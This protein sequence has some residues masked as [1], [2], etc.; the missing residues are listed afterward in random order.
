[1]KQLLRKIFSEKLGVGKVIFSGLGFVLGLTLVLSA[2][3]AYLAVNDYLL[4]KQEHPD[5]IILNKKVGIGNT[6]FGSKVA[7]TP[8]EVEDL[9][10]QPFVEGLAAFVPNQ[11][12]VRAHAGGSMGLLTD[13]FFESLPRQFIDDV[14]A[15][16]RWKNESDMVPIIVSREFLNLYNFG[17]AVGKNKPQISESTI[18][19]LPV[20]VEIY[21]AGGKM[22]FK[23]KVV[24][25]SDR[26]PSFLVPEEFMNWANTTIAGTSSEIKPSR[27]IVKVRPEHAG[28]MEKYLAERDL[29]LN[30]D[31]IKYSKVLSVLNLAMTIVI[32][33]GAAFMAFALLIVIMNFTLL[34]TETKQEISLLIQLGYKR[35]QI[36]N[37][38]FTYFLIFLFIVTG[39]SI[40]LFMV[41]NYF[42][43]QALIVHKVDLMIAP[44][45]AVAVVLIAVVTG[46]AL[47]SYYSLDRVIKKTY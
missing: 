28:M 37:H 8:E 31:R 17:F 10:K 19:M 44:E 39:A 14:P 18:Q 15:S 32:F 5:Y 43:Q 35:K 33:I 26:I 11:F 36:L 47:V 20:D 7:F 16:F 42:L 41:G 24:G 46:A 12:S 34:I 21:G 45:L 23:A 27:I 22:T 29:S 13:L 2:L 3:Q 38:L 1:M 4:P 6:I 25:Y 9:K 40:L 30:E